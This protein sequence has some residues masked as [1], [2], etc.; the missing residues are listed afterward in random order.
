MMVRISKLLTIASLLFFLL[1]GIF[2]SMLNNATEKLNQKEKILQEY[3]ED[4]SGFIQYDTSLNYLVGTRDILIS[5][6]QSNDF[7]L[8]ELIEKRDKELTDYRVKLIRKLEKL[9]NTTEREIT[10][11]NYNDLELM[12][13]KKILIGKNEAIAF[14]LVTEIKNIKDEKTNRT[15]WRNIFFFLGLVMQISS[16]FF[17]KEK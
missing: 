8:R 13:Y 5:M 2:E 7:S 16:E 15:F 6:D 9:T 17:K 11:D 1:T 4:I 3:N 10:K 12:D 14:F